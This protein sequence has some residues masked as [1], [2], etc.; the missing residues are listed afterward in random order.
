[1]LIYGAGGH[2][3]VVLSI[4][5]ACREPVSGV[6]DDNVP[7]EAFSEYQILNAYDRHF[8]QIE[9]LIIAIG[10]NHD[11]RQ[12]AEK[13]VHSFGKAI[14]PTAVVDPSVRVGSG[15]VIVHGAIIQAGS[16]VG[17][18]VIVNTAA[19]IDHD[20][21]LEDFV[22]IAPGATLCGGVRVGECTLI[23]AG[24]VVAPQ[25]NIGKECIIGSGTVV[26]HDVPD[27]A[28]VMGNPARINI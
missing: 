4:F 26:I 19:T 5:S 12:L 6:F 15:T 3:K 18:H 24:A 25:V 2:A 20:C 17:S 11:R 28:K 10:N 8:K 1:M 9:A 21:F 23:G 14:H 13:I 16:Y 22:H 7:S 27:F